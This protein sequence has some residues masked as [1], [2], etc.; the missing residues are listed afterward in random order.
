M[1]TPQELRA[2]AE[3]CY[4][5]G[6]AEAALAKYQQ[7]L[8]IQPS[9]PGLLSD[10][11]TVCFALGR[12]RQS[13]GYFLEA[14]RLDPNHIAARNNLEMLRKAVGS[15]ESRTAD[16][17]PAAKA[18]YDIQGV[19]VVVPAHPP[20]GGFAVLEKC[21]EGLASQT[22]PLDRYEVLVVANGVNAPAMEELHGI[23]RKRQKRLGDHLRLFAVERASIPIARNEGIKRARGRIILQTNAD[24]LLSETALAQ[25]CEEHENAGFDPCHVVIGGRRFPDSYRRSLFNYLYEEMP[26][27]Q[28]LHRPNMRFLADY[29][30]LVTTNMTALKE[31]YALFGGY[32]TSLGW[33]S[34]IAIGQRWEQDHRA[35]L[36]V[37]THIASHHI[38]L[39]SFDVW[40]QKMIETVPFWLKSQV[41]LMPHELP[42]QAYRGL[43]KEM[44]GIDVDFAGVEAEIRRIE[45]NFT[46]PENFR[47]ETVMGSRVQTLGEF[48]WFLRALLNKY[49]NQLKIAELWRLMEESGVYANPPVGGRPGSHDPPAGGLDE[50]KTALAGDV[51]FE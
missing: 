33:N 8:Q 27:G 22:L 14:L 3:R 2:E 15:R 23:I 29:H 32:D 19:S 4:E 38:H 31:A 28:P 43:K 48:V 42:P 51:P 41:G 39:L 37:N 6:Q 30:W 11:G 21:L 5:Q 1:S 9:D 40:R 34:D 26:L 18:D 44:D 24:I 12:V 46:G 10:V 17:A 16:G 35:R 49:R 47:G 50:I 7:L 25:H 36:Y 20:A 45:K 13:E